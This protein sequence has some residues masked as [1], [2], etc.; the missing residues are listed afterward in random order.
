MY[1][2]NFRRAETD[3]V[4][5]IGSGAVAGSWEPVYDALGARIPERSA[6]T[7]NVYFATLVHRLRWLHRM[8]ANPKAHPEYRQLFVEALKEYRGVTQ[9][10]STVLRSR[11]ETLRLRP[12][13]HA[14]KELLLD[15]RD[16][17]RAFHIATT[18]WDFSAQELHDEDRDPCPSISFLHGTFSVGLYLPGEAID[19]PYRGADNLHEFEISMLSTVHALRDAERLIVYGLSFS[20]LDAE[21]GYLLQSAAS[22]RVKLF[23]HVFVIDV[24]PAT[25][26]TR[27]RVHLG[28]QNF[29]GVRPEDVGRLPN[30]CAESR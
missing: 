19:E 28:N 12:E 6:E 29:V 20:P 2:A 25:V 15:Q 24:K 30:P 11:R 27:L 18:N 4:V 21:L 14:I 23:E 10:I 3:T 26:I 17:F 13:A 9:E 5:F 1:L 8:A 16:D 7:A 22:Q